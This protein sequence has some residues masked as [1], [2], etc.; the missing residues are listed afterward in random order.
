MVITEGSHPLLRPCMTLCGP[1]A[2]SVENGRDVSIRQAPRLV[3][4]HS[5]LT[6]AQCRKPRIDGCSIRFLNCVAGE[7]ED[8]QKASGRVGSGVTNSKKSAVNVW[9]R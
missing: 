5:D 4:K 6:F 1:Y 2:K 9:P 3:V 7:I 8:S